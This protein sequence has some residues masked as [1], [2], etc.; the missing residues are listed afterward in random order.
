VWK[1]LKLLT[2][3]VL[4]VLLAWATS[5]VWQPLFESDEAPVV[6]DGDDRIHVI[7]PRGLEYRTNVSLSSRYDEETL[8]ESQPKLLISIDINERGYIGDSRVTGHPRTFSLSCWINIPAQSRLGFT[9]HATSAHW[10]L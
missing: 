1:R 4:T 10:T 5:P 3:V 8:T 7:G 2:L 9:S 6:W